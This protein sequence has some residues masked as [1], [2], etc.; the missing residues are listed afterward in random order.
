MLGGYGLSLDA[1]TYHMMQAI[2]HSKFGKI[3][4]NSQGLV[5]SELA[6]PPTQVESQVIGDALGWSSQ[7]VIDPAIRLKRKADVDQVSVAWVA[8]RESNRRST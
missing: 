2:G 7:G 6:Q 8:N 4:D 1:R 3:H 5:G